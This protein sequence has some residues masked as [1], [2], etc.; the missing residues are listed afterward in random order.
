MAI[1]YKDFNGKV[2]TV[3]AGKAPFPVADSSTIGGVKVTGGP[4]ESTPYK[5]MSEGA[6]N[7]KLFD[8]AKKDHT[9]LMKDI[10]KLDE[11][12][13]SKAHISHTHDDRYYTE[14]EVDG[15]VSQIS[16]RIDQV[17]GELSDKAPIGHTHSDYLTISQAGQVY[18]PKSAMALYATKEDLEKVGGSSYIYQ[19]AEFD[20]TAG[21][22]ALG[23]LKNKKRIEDVVID[24][25]AMEAVAQS[26]TAMRAVVESSTAAQAMIRS[27]VALDIIL[28]NSIAMR[29]V[30][31]KQDVIKI[32]VNSAEIMKNMTGNPT[33]MMAIAD[34]PVAMKEI[35]ESKF[36]VGLGNS[37]SYSGRFIILGANSSMDGVTRYSNPEIP[38]SVKPTEKYDSMFG[39]LYNA[40]KV[41]SNQVYTKINTYYG[42]S[43]LY[44][45][46][47]DKIK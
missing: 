19:L 5:V 32:L 21:T 29:I 22:N 18:Q 31:G 28:K 17:D 26:Y 11:F 34:S 7:G 25:V 43:V 8:Y 37:G 12:L 10:Y 40:L 15:K 13:A 47:L 27:S 38:D 45:L 41:V 33:A 24:G 23:A 9:H 4:G 1:Y 14:S 30:A 36:T 20:T 42:D 44:V 16:T 35:T 39:T 3:V 46:D 2:R 6:V